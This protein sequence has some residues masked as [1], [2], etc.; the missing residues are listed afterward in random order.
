MNYSLLLG[1][2]GGLFALLNNLTDETKEIIKSDSK[3]TDDYIKD[4]VTNKKK[5]NATVEQITIGKG[6]FRKVTLAMA[7]LST[8]VNNP[9]D[10]LCIKKS[11]PFEEIAKILEKERN[12]KI[13]FN[14]ILYEEMSNFLLIIFQRVIQ[15]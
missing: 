9:G 10:I 13:S 7:I 6:G 14:Q 3:I 5:G 1:S 4:K 8:S 12:E 15:I 11:K 2:D